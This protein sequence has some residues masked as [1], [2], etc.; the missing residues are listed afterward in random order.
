[1]HTRKKISSIE[2]EIRK[3]KEVKA[4]TMH[5]KWEKNTKKFNKFFLSFFLIHSCLFFLF[6]IMECLLCVRLST[7]DRI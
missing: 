2:N 5:Q 6:T 1:M 7:G 3:N 4:K